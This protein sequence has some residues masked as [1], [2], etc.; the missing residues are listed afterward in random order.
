MRP[1]P[2]LDLLTPRTTEAR[3]QEILASVRAR[4][5][6]RPAVYRMIAADGE[7]VYV[8]KSKQLRSRLLSYF[9]GE[10]PDDKGARILREADAI[11]W[12]YVPSE[13][14]ALLTELRYIKRYRPRLNVAMKRDG[15]NL[16]FI[17][18]TGGVAPRLTVVRGPGL[19]DRAMYYGPFLGAQ[20]VDESLRE[21]SDVLG[22]R[23]CALDKQMKFSDQ[24]ELFTGPPRTPGCLRYEVQKC[25]GPCIAACSSV[26][27]MGRVGMA[28]AFLDGTDDGPVETLRARMTTSSDRLEYERA[29]AYRDKLHRLEALRKEFGRLRFAVESLSFLY[30]VTGYDGADR[31]YVVRRGR[32]RGEMD[33]PFSAEGRAALDQLLSDTFGDATTGMQVPSHEIDELLL[34][35]SWFRRFPAE[36]DR[37]AAVQR[38]G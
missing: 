35:S 15:R 9:R 36:L 27:Y 34:L 5:E 23:D 12:D 18:L 26:E 28:R 31:L 10:Y 20:R 4:A 8:G 16:C 11:E 38:A 29:A 22:M 14:A 33:A 32:V 6:N 13:F 19:D 1:L 7:V 21:L 30:T 2:R 24:A 3:V 37:T 25:I 17:K